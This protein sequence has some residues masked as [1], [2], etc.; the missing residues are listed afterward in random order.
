MSLSAEECWKSLITRYGAPLEPEHLDED[1][2]KLAIAERRALTTSR[3]SDGCGGGDVYFHRAQVGHK[4]AIVF[5]RPCEITDE[6]VAALDHPNPWESEADLDRFTYRILSPGCWKSL[7][8]RYGVPL[9][10][11]SLDEDTL[12]L[13][14]AERRALKV[15]EAYRYIKVE[16]KNGY[17][18]LHKSEYVYFRRAEVGDAIKGFYMM[19]RPYFCIAFPQPCEITNKEA[20]ILEQFPFEPWEEVCKS[21]DEILR[22]GQGSP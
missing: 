5:P 20:R 19:D 9:E 12:K 3:I 14:I 22:E 13:A 2:L 6:E 1:T 7:I 17:A 10:P 16:N 11:E 4:W 8:T 18:D 15:V 21:T